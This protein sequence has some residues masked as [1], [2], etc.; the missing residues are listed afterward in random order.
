M[1]VTL[2]ETTEANAEQG[3]LDSNLARIGGLLQGQRDL[4]EVCSMI[5]DEVAPLVDAQVGAFFLADPPEADP[6]AGR[7]HAQRLVMCA[8]YG[9]V[10]AVRGRR[11]AVVPARRGAG[12]PGRRGRAAGC[13]CDDVPAGL[14]ADP[15]RGRR[16]PRR[17]RW[18][19]CRSCSRASTL[20]VIEFGSVTPFSRAAP[21]LPRAAGRHHRRR[22][23][24]HPG[25][26]AHRGA[27]RAVPAAGRGA[28]GPVGR[29]AAHQRR[30]GGEGR[31]AVRAEPQHRDQ[32]HGDRRGPA[33]RR[34][35]GP[36]AR[37][38]P[39]STSRS[40]WPT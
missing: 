6:T 21:D 30:A 3:W 9:V 2:R 36:A 32:E 19:C 11:A 14:P 31:A 20:G 10:P 29:A 37:R 7:G 17:A 33:R 35:E 38:R 26:P 1:I 34:G 28:A 24:H 15:L 23:P 4:G 40:S 13:W 39:A 8:G 18:S 12:R 27:A 16:R 22:A 5:M 25:Q